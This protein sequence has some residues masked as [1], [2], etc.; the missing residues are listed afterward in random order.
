MKARF[1]LCLIFPFIAKATPGTGLDYEL[2]FIYGG[3]ALLM[4]FIV[5]CD[6]LLRLIMKK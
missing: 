1:V 5:G 4:F 3:F 2:L 6:K